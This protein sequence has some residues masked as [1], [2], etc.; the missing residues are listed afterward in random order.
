VPVSRWCRERRVGR[1]E[2]DW[3]A[4]AVAKDALVV[5]WDWGCQRCTQLVALGKA[6]CV[7]TRLV[8]V[9]Q[10]EV[11]HLWPVSVSPTLTVRSMRRPM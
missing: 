9:P 3:K 11:A 2:T 1:Y 6:A 5:F 8:R 7:P 4:L 10:S